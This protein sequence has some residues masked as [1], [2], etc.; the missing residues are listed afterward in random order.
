MSY[1]DERV[2]EMQFNNKDFEKNVATSLNT[3]DKLQAALKLDGSQK[4]LETLQKTTNHF[5]LDPLITAAENVN[6]KFSA[7]GIAGTAALVRITNKAIDAG[8][9]LIK[10]LSVDNIS[11]GWD[12]FGEK[13]KSVGTLVSQGF[14]L[15]TVEEQMERLNWFTDETSYNF[16]DMVSNISKFTATGKGLEESVSAMEGIA[17]WAAASGQNATKASMAMYQLSQ[18]MGKGVLKYD[19]WKSI[20]NASMDTIEFRKEA[21]KAAVALGKVKQVSE[22][23]YEIV[24]TKKPQQFSLADMF[25]SDALSR[26]QWFTDEV[27]MKV[28][29]RYNEASDKI[30]EYIKAQRRLGKTVTA[31]QAIEALGDD[32]DE[33]SK[34]WFLAGQ[35]ARTFGDVIDSVKDAVSTGWMI[36]FE[37][38]FG[39][40][41]EAT[42]LFTNLAETLYEIFAEGGNARNEILRLWKALGGRDVMLNGLAK[43]FENVQRFMEP[44]NK[45]LG[46]FFSG[47][48]L[49]KANFLWEISDALYSFAEGLE[50]TDKA[51]ESFYD[52][53]KGVFSIGGLLVD[54]FKT[55]LYVLEPLL[56]PLNLLAGYIVDFFAAIGRGITGI[57]N[58]T[59]ASS[60]IA[61]AINGAR[62]AVEIF[63][64]K[65][66]YGIA[67]VA[68]FVKYFWQFVDLNKVVKTFSHNL[69]NMATR[70]T[71]YFSKV[72]TVVD[73]VRRKFLDFFNLANI[74]SGFYTAI[75][76]IAEKLS[77]IGT[78][79][80]NAFQKILPY[81]TK[82]KTVVIDFFN[83][84]SNGTSKLQKVDILGKIGSV[85][86]NVITVL[87]NAK[88]AVSSFIQSIREAESPLVVIQRVI[89]SIIKRFR[90]LRKTFNNYIQNSPFKDF[91]K[92]ITDAFDAIIKKLKEMGASRILLF[93]FGVAVTTMMLE[94]GNAASKAADMFTQI[95]TIPKLISTY[96]SKIGRLSA[97]NSILQVAEAIGIL[98]LS[99]KLLST[100]DS[101]KLK[102]SASALLLL[103]AAMA[104]IAVIMNR[105]GSDSGFAANATGIVALSGSIVLLAVAF[106]L[107]S[108]IEFNKALE[109]L[110]VMAAFALGLTVVS[111]LLGVAAKTSWP[112]VA[113]LLAFAFS[114]EKLVNAFVKI[115]TTMNPETIEKSLDTLKVMMIG[116]AAL[117][118][119]A[120]GLSAGSAIGLLG[121]I[122]SL[123]LVYKMM[124]KIANS[125][126]DFNLIK[127]N[128]SKFAAVFVFL[129]G[130]FLTTRFAGKNAIGAAASILAIAFAMKMLT[131][132]LARLVALSVVLSGD[133][134]VLIN[135]VG[136]LAVMMTGIGALL[137][138]TQYAG[139]YAVRGAASI[140]ILVG[141]MYLMT[142]LI[143]RIDKMPFLNWERT[144]ITFAGISAALVAMI[145]ITKLTE[146]AKVGV[147]IAM[148][149]AMGVLFSAVALLTP[150]AEQNNDAFMSVCEGLTWTLLALGGLFFLIGKMTKDAKTGP[151]AATV[152]AMIVLIGGMMVLADM[153]TNQGVKVE[154]L[155]E[156]AKSLGL[157]LVAFGGMF[158]LLGWAA[159]IA[160]DS[161]KGVGAIL[162]VML[163]LIPAAAAMSMLYN[164]FSASADPTTIVASVGSLL[165]V[166]FAAAK[167][168]SMAN[169]ALKGAGAM[170]AMSAALAISAASI[171]ILASMDMDSVMTAALALIGIMLTFAGLS[172]LGTQLPEVVLIMKGFADSL[173]KASLSMLVAAA[174]AYIIAAAIKLVVDAIKELAG[175]TDNEA[176]Q[177]GSNL[178]QIIGDLGTAIGT[179]LVNMVKTILKAIGDM[180]VSITDKFTQNREGLKATAMGV[181]GGILDGIKEIGLGILTAIGDMILGAVSCFTGGASTIGEAATNAFMSIP[182]ALD[183]MTQGA[184][185]TIVNFVTSVIDTIV[186][187]GSTLYDLAVGCVGDF[188][189][190]IGSMISTAV[191][192][193]A[194]FAKSILDAFNIPLQINSPS[195]AFEDSGYN[196]VMGVINGIANGASYAIT[197]VTTM[198]KDLLEAFCVA[199]GIHS[200]SKDFS[201]EGENI[202]YGAGEGIINN[203]S[204]PVTATNIMCNDIL[205]E[206]SDVL[207]AENAAA[208]GGNF[209]VNLMSTVG[210]VL[211]KFQGPKIGIGSDGSLVFGD[212]KGGGISGKAAS[213]VTNALL[214]G[215]GSSGLFKPKNFKKQ[216]E[217]TIRGLKRDKFLGELRRD[218]LGLAKG[219]LDKGTDKVKELLDPKLPGG[220]AGSGKGGKG[221]SGSGLS[222]KAEKAAKEID[223]LTKIT[224][225][226]DREI[227]IFNNHWA[228]GLDTLGNVEPMQASKDALELLALQLYETSL[229][230]ET[231]DDRAKR[232]A[233]S[234]PELLE[235]VK[236]AYKDYRDEVKKTIDG[237]VDMFKM[238]DFGKK[239]RPEEMIENQK[240]NLRAI[241]EYAQNIE[242][243]AERGLSKD[244]LQNFGKRGLNSLADM[245]TLIQM[246]D[247]QFKQFNEDWM[248]AGKM[249]DDVTNRYMSSLA[250]VNAGSQEGFTQTLNPETGEET[251]KLYMQAVLEG[252]REKA[253]LNLQGGDGVS[254]ATKEIAE[255]LSKG[256]T[257]TLGTSGEKDKAASAAGELGSKVTEAI[258]NTAS[259]DAG[260]QIGV[261]LCEGIA[262]GIRSGIEV[263]TTAAEELALKLVETVKNALGIA[264]PSKVFEDLGYYSDLGLSGGLTKYG[265]IVREAAA[266]TATS[267]VNEMTGVFGRIADLI[268][269]NLDLDPTIRPV[270]DLTNL[271]YGATQIGSLL[272]LNDPY[273]L[274]AVAGITGIQND[275]S[276]MASLTGS[277]TDA[278]NGM[279]KDQETPQVTINI[280]PQEGQSAEEIAEEVSWRLNHDVFKRR[281][282]YGGT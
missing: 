95:T 75:N 73:K 71:P 152:A 105:F 113:M 85:I 40:Y 273:A 39:N 153:V 211:G 268:D 25:T 274:N 171:A 97:T 96:I 224:D 240:S 218:P 250:F 200:P 170:V 93:A 1:I 278:I 31:S 154:A 117:A 255:G 234:T 230:G 242:T 49:D 129:S 263:A 51:F 88:N 79:G 48:S 259:T 65:L 195:G 8:E 194:D 182:Q 77:K 245:G 166:M 83:S 270:L 101:D 233:K 110:G 258:D 214:G 210:S 125:T 68:E 9:A 164:T 21:L 56:L 235:D 225:Y 47:D 279:K 5:N 14:D 177:I 238:F 261:N 7:M 266:D 149:A 188:I 201:D 226:A 22:D 46:E 81:F 108:K 29:N 253:G 203:T 84:F 156:I 135:T 146:K 213:G 50:I 38:I 109:S 189:D 119:A 155:W 130:L 246:T 277:L 202:P 160:K 33:Q 102:D 118:F 104:V 30:N 89:D 157:V 43:A 35:E 116:L 107:L 94:I 122:F 13:T 16:T 239:I 193:V 264:S 241:T 126:I 63:A 167:F 72:V 183:Y 17:L 281:A 41:Q 199:L 90:D 197:A 64:T 111:R 221:G 249:I 174:S 82:A 139:K 37:Q 209:A 207:S 205:D 123:D 55:L 36:T 137:Y 251:G 282:V 275:A 216:Y 141:V 173:F 70:I 176:K 144:M 18:A 42:E 91:A 227:G 76:S 87:T 54:A 59:H 148:I 134:N 244:I 231:A 276:L 103:S 184:F 223:K 204:Y 196:C 60:G 69:K 198:A 163:S 140:L 62:I 19:D 280:Y 121:I 4:G 260:K 2:V 180:F 132:V 120:G 3:L 112:Q 143:D 175:I 11:K 138:V 168:A 181:F 190:G 12:K 219:A 150:I 32:L 127:D 74:N 100:I 267:A 92:N 28:F 187:F 178:I 133:I 106:G 186:E 27:M 265:T 206:A 78:A 220:G 179:G 158:V 45:A 236:K 185:S 172:A 237:Q 212:G 66:A 67:Y 136:M 232:M 272:G 269:G 142:N 191:E 115:S 57:R 169:D 24:G 52:I 26:Q 229:A 86:S 147:I 243:L 15:S 254:E 222:D 23:V 162:I 34:K 114:I 128:I 217:K 228:L 98:A 247:E 131:N 151:I 6:N 99:L 208:I 192:A 10:S 159:R 61:G 80:S 124:E 20:Q 53:W 256:V 271:Q 257:E 58:F 161:I 262:E 215:N 248:K 145:A 165:V 252:M 44:F